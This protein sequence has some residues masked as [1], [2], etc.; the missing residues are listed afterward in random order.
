MTFYYDPLYCNKKFFRADL[1][2]LASKIFGQIG[3]KMCT[4]PQGRVFFVKFT[5]VTFAFLLCP[6]TLQS[7][8]K[9]VRVNP[10][11]IAFVIFG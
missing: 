4:F 7:F 10:E 1:E 11:I 9:F 8:R 2:I 6:I 5:Y 3:T